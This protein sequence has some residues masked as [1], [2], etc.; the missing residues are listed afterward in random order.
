LSWIASS[1]ACFVS[2]DFADKLEYDW[3]ALLFLVGISLLFIQSA[4]LSAFEWIYFDWKMF[5][6]R[7]RRSQIASHSH[8][9]DLPSEMEYWYNIINRPF[10]KGDCYSP[11]DG[12][13]RIFWCDTTPPS[14]ILTVIV[15]MTDN[16]D[17]IVIVAPSVISLTNRCDSGN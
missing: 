4:G 10:S 1:T 14:Q 7:W 17:F 2:I 11:N 9:S 6:K 3:H 12:K 13:F 15:F 8:N 5:A 16:N